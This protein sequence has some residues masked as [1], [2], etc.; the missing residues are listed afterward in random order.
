MWNVKRGG[1]NVEF[2]AECDM[3]NFGVESVDCRV[4]TSRLQWRGAASPNAALATQNRTKDK[5]NIA[6]RAAVP[7]QK[8]AVAN[9]NV[10]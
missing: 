4:G 8:V 5:G 1:R 3:L 7:V 10:S 9:M 6:P 2:G